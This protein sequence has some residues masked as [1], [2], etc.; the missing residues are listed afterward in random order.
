MNKEKWDL[1]TEEDKMELVDRLMSAL[2]EM[3]DYADDGTIDIEEE[4]ADE[5]SDYYDFAVSVLEA[6]EVLDFGAELYR[7]K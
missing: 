6:R 5:D 1:L 4:Y 3:L 2:N 7:K